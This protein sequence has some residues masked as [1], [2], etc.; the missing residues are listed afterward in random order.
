MSCARRGRPYEHLDGCRDHGFCCNACK[1]NEGK[2]TK[3]CTGYMHGRSDFQYDGYAQTQSPMRGQVGFRIPTRQSP[4]RGQVG[5]RIPTSWKSG[6]KFLAHID[7]YMTRF[8]FAMPTQDS[9]LTFQQLA[10]LQVNWERE[11]VI[12]VRPENNPGPGPSINLAKL[13]LN[14]HRPSLYNSREVSGIYFEVQAVLLSQ[15]VCACGLNAAADKI[16]V[17]DLAEFTFVCTHA[18]H[19]SA[20][21][22]CLLASLIYNN[23]RIM[24]STTRTQADA[25]TYGMIDT[26][27][28]SS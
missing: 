21:M 16:E 26:D 12:H 20:G 15:P 2:H 9:W 14:G 23:A 19:R 17:E 13:N 18:T 10:N 6:P 24:F 7:W 28:A 27:V 11:L 22:A 8:G 3:N 5:F 25:R 4:M 1:R